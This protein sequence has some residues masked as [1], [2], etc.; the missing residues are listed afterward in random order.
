[1]TI[2]PSKC[3]FAKKEVQFLGYIINENGTRPLAKTVKAI[4]DFPKPATVKQLRRF[5]GIINF[6]R[7]F[8]SKAARLQSPLKHLL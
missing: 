4:E 7:R 6:Y 5:L 8:I 3:T 1:M 2:N